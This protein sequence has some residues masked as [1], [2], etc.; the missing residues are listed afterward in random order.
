MQRKKI[1]VLVFFISVIFKSTVLMAQPQEEPVIIDGDRVEYSDEQ[2]MVHGFGNV[3]VRYK[4][5][6]LTADKIAF[7][8]ESK[9]AIAE[10]NVCLYKDE[11]VFKGKYGHYDFNTEKGM[12][13]DVRFI[14]KPVYGAG[15]EVEKTAKKTFVAKQ[16]FFTT[17]PFEKPHY[18]FQSKQLTVYLDDKIVANHVIF[19]IGDF[20]FLYLPYYSYSLRDD[21]PRVTVIP[22]HNK[23]WGTYVLSA[24]RYYFSDDSMG[25]I[26]LDWREKRGVA[27][28]FTHKYKIKNFGRGTL[29]AYYMQERLRDIPEG[30][31]AEDE[32]FRIKLLHDWKPDG[33][34]RV[35]LEYHRQSDKDFNKD[36]FYRE[37]IKEKRPESHFSFTKKYPHYSINFYTRVRVNQF[38]TVTQ[39]MPEITFNM[40]NYQFGD[41]KFYY[42]NKT[43]F[44]NFNKKKANAGIAAGNTYYY[45]TDTHTTRID[46]YNK[47]SYPTKLP[48][49]VKWLKFTPYLDLRES[50]YTRNAA[51]TKRDFFR[52]VYG[53]GYNLTTKIFRI[54][55][56][57]KDLWGIKINKLRH[58]I[59]PAI[60]YTYIHDPTVPA[61]TLDQFDSIDTINTKKTYVFRLN[62]K[63]Q[64]KWVKGEGR[65]ET[66]NLINF[67]SWIYLNPQRE[68][69]TFSDVYLALKLLPFRWLTLNSST[70]YDWVTR[71]FEVFNLNLKLTKPRWEISA[72]HR[73]LT[74]DYSETTFRALYHLTSKW[75]VGFYERYDFTK[76]RLNE[77]EYFLAR[78]FHDWI[79]ELTWNIKDAETMMIVFRN[80]AFPQ[81]PLQF[82]T[83]YHEPKVGSQSEPIY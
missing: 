11:G 61:S 18:R 31:K 30:L 38:E 82:E 2:K 42:T 48:G 55:D 77:Q 57:K 47:L 12:V 1:F 23:E 76:K 21:R 67:D 6:T 9:E 14:S 20:P 27:E 34:T 49:Y 45:T 26:H 25:R 71:D 44:S 59:T 74:N 32:R 66:V 69:R 33:N 17:C 5:M 63:L 39:R 62:N 72:G 78:D 79:I 52:N 81:A 24:W 64:T 53:G 68:G 54:W 22:G 43:S 19:F 28:G 50:F 7:D 4:D 37:Y 51:G 58:L 13:S 60:D 8:V 15:E 10:G 16:G 29:H 80:K 56:T 75:Q 35:F 40:L 3:I 46:T 41:T 73:F 70:A 36:F 65:L 83:S